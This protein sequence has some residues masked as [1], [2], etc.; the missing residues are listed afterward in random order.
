MP[1]LIGPVVLVVAVGF[2]IYYFRRGTAERVE[3]RR[4]IEAEGGHVLASRRVGLFL[5]SPFPGVRR[6]PL[7]YEYRCRYGDREGTWF[8]AASADSPA[9]DWVWRD[10]QARAE[11][12]VV[13]R[14]ARVDNHAS[15]LGYVMGNIIG[16]GVVSVFAVVLIYLG[17]R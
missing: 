10:G 4:T 12:P 15:A 6:C 16:V 9:G 17:L 13:R 7:Y 3:F 5:R 14:D 1:L 8:V 2:A 11:L